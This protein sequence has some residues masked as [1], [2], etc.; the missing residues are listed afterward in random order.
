MIW[1]ANLVSVLMVVNIILALAI[2][3]LERRNIAAT[4]S[5]LV[6]LLFIPVLGFLLYVV[7]GRNLSHRRLY[8]LPK[9]EL[10]MVQTM[11]EDQ[12]RQ[13]EA[14][15]MNFREPD[16]ARYRDMIYM[17]VRASYSLL[18][19]DN[20][21]DIFTDGHAKFETLLQ[22]IEKAQRHIHLL[23]YIIRDDELGRRVIGS[24][25]RKAREGL[26][27]RILYD[28]IGS[29]S[30]SPR[31]FRE[32]K[33]AGG[34][35][36]AFFPSTIR[37]LNFRVNF[38]NH[39]KLAVI[40][41][42]I[43]YI[44]GFNIGNEYI[45][46]D[47]YMGFWRDTHLRVS[48]SAVHTMQAM[49]LL[50]WNLAASSRVDYTPDYFPNWNAGGQVPMQIVGSGPN[51][52]WR[53]IENAYIKMIH[54]AKKTVYVQT[55]Y[56]IPDDGLLNALIIASLSGIDVRVMVPGKPDHMFVHWA[57]YYYLGELLQAG[58][59]CYLYKNGFLHAK[60]IVVDGAIASVGTANFDFRSLKLNFEANAMIYD[61][62]VAEQLQCIYIKD[63]EASEE[64]T[65]ENYR[66]RSWS[67]RIKESVSRLL[68]PI[69]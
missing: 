4:W 28:D 62:N 45:G 20:H 43:G 6:V 12:I 41:G 60:T 67:I 31:F 7:L 26:E 64:L 24:L 21:V 15:S 11:A 46:L 29:S 50:D 51:T 3:F 23:Y 37:Y 68:S 53:H 9:S 39:R 30:V 61:H 18:S 27:V 10:M 34:E 22:D 66:N 33:E 38:R 65:M 63:I 19:Q 16:M 35:V 52:R 69:L 59:K 58:V 13:L 25:T 47:Q 55:P 2:I 1:L 56:F 49:F 32:L 57:S 8:K 14:G 17:N 36:A 42:K 48:G 40:D 5:W 54:A 44:G